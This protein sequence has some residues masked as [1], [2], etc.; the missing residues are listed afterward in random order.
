M[1]T[2]ELKEEK[3]KKTITR[4]R[5]ELEALKSDTAGRSEADR[6]LMRRKIQ[7]FLAR[8]EEITVE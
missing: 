4:A 5:K 2:E 6:T 8:N 3:K 1:V 7:T